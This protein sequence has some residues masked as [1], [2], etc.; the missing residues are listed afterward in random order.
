MKNHRFLQAVMRDRGFCQ[1]RYGGNAATK[2]PTPKKGM[3]VLN[4][5]ECRDMAPVPHY[6]Q[7]PS[8]PMVIPMRVKEEHE[9][10]QE[11]ALKVR[12]HSK[13]VET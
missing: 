8:K 5:A 1:K 3:R 7:A 13:N 11:Q 4:V 6:P 10:Q 2:Y 9:K 12:R